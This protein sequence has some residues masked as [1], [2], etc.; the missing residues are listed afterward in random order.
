MKTEVLE[1]IDFEKESPECDEWNKK[2][3]EHFGPFVR[4]M[5]AIDT[6]NFCQCEIADCSHMIDILHIH[7]EIEDL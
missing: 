6:Y 7:S 2:K 1:K 4:L 3:K 5:R